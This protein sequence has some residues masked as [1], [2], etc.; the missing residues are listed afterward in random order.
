MQHIS[1]FEYKPLS[2]D[3]ELEADPEKLRNIR[4]HH[5][6]KAKIYAANNVKA[7]K[8]RTIA[9]SVKSVNNPLIRDNAAVGAENYKR[10]AKKLK[11]A[12]RYGGAF[13]VGAGLLAGGA[14][15]A[16]KDKEKEFSTEQ[17][18]AEFTR[19]YSNLVPKIP[20][21]AKTRQYMAEVLRETRSHIRAGKAKGLLGPQVAAT[22]HDTSHVAES[23]FLNNPENRRKI[24]TYHP[25]F[26]L[27]KKYKPV[28]FTHSNEVAGAVPYDTYLSNKEHFR[29][30]RENPSVLENTMAVTSDSIHNQYQIDK[31]RGRGF[32][33]GSEVVK[34]GAPKTLLTKQALNSALVA[35]AN[36]ADIILNDPEYVRAVATIRNEA[37]IKSQDNPLGALPGYYGAEAKNSYENYRPKTRFL[38]G[39]ERGQQRLATIEKIYERKGLGNNL[40]EVAANIKSMDS[41]TR[42]GTENYRKGLLKQARQDGARRGLEFSSPNSYTRIKSVA[43][44]SIPMKKVLYNK[45]TQENN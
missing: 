29:L 17:Q 45:N 19:Y 30:N 2:I 5:L 26:R 27:A 42:K 41:N 31:A 24:Q 25:D 23:V 16:S 6:D 3:K 10:A 8:H 33:T 13:L 9:S 32:N 28:G 39:K 44:F 40:E 35:R 20:A 36:T 1:S 14:Y 11:Q 34:S 18:L 21:N 22:G 15:L 7:A 38:K 4:R 43:S 37:D 12:Q